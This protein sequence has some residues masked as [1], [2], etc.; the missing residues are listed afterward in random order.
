VLEA[1]ATGVPSIGFADCPGT[2]ELIVHGS[3][4]LLADAAD[5]IEGL[6]SA[7]RRLMGSAEERARMGAQA[8]DDARSFEPAQ[9]YDQWER[10]LREAAEYAEASDCLLKEQQ[11]VDFERVLHAIR[12]RSSL[13]NF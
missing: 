10:T 5:R 12:V 11:R 9:V 13:M 3:N 8:R 6:A 4:G 2:N 1:M 7:L